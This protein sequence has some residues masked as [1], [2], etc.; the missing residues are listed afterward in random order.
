MRLTLLSED[1]S[2]LPDG[3]LAIGEHFSLVNISGDS[4]SPEGASAFRV[5]GPLEHS[6]PGLIVMDVDSTLLNEEVIEVLAERAGT[7]EEVA[8]VTEAAMRGELDFEQSLHARVATLAGLP[9][10]VIAATIDAVTL[11]PGARELVG[12][13]HGAGARVAL[14]S[15]GFAEVVGPIAAGLGI[16]E[17]HAN[18]LEIQDGRLTGRV[19]GAVVDRAAKAG[20]LRRIAAENAVDP[21]L[22]VAIGDGAND[23]DMIEEAGFGIAFCAKPALRDAADAALDFRRLDAAWAGLTGVIAQA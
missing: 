4:P 1:P 19:T 2:V 13:A 12:L 6:A 7:R 16:A 15:G 20:H 9:E 5:D 8:R 14:V 23:L 11:T 22:T 3:D 17:V 18:R 10:E 21:A